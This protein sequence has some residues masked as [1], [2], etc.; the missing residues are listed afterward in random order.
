MYFEMVCFVLITIYIIYYLHKENKT[1][2]TLSNKPEAVFNKFY[3]INEYLGSEKISIVSYNILC[4]KCLRRNNRKDLSLENRIKVI[5]NELRSLKADIICLQ[6]VNMYTYK[7]YLLPNFP[8]YHFVYLR[9]NMGSNFINLIGYKTDKFRL[10]KQNFL[11][12]SD[13][14]LEGNRGVYQVI[15]KTLNN[16]LVSVY[17][18]H[19]PWRPCY[20][21]EKC[22][23]LN[24]IC[25]NIFKDNIEHVIISGDFNSLPNSIVMRMIYFN[26]F[27][28]EC[29]LYMQNINFEDILNLVEIFDRKLILTKESIR[30][31]SE[32]YI[33]EKLIKE[34]MIN[35]EINLKYKKIFSN[36]SELFKKYCFKSAYDGYIGIDPGFITAH[37]NFTNFTEKFKA[38]IDYIFYSKRLRLLKVL[39]LPGLS[40]VTAEEFLP[41]TR[42]PSDHLKIYSEFEII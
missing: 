32:K 30:T 16:T 40:E 11:D 17:N 35:E 12:I 22:Y 41:S 4:Q 10:M 39:E 33:F 20:E 3:Q 26:K 27:I 37:P 28:E 29:R 38:T 19:F 36:F 18:V 34:L 1:D 6:E 25:E 2:N 23:I 21:L 31:K 13:I 42:Y 15:L 24:S 5:I 9:E 14:Y 8:E 7:K